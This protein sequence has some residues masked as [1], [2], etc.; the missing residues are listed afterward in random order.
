MP[1]HAKVEMVVHP[2][3][4]NVRIAT[5]H[6]GQV[7]G[8]AQIQTQRCPIT[9]WASCD[10]EALEA[11]LGRLA[12]CIAK[13]RGAP[14]ASA[15]AFQDWAKDTASK[16][17]KAKVIT[18]L[19]TQAKAVAKNPA[20]ARAGGLSTVVVPG[21]SRAVL[22]LQSASE[23]IAALKRKDPKTVTAWRLM[24]VNAKAGNEKAKRSV[25]VVYAVARAPRI[26]SPHAAQAAPHAAAHPSHVARPVHPAHVAHH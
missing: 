7:I 20:V 6:S 17:A 25:H 3:L 13:M 12:A 9:F 2:P 15:G 19:A 23:M 10:L 8:M 26:I 11:V 4:V 24:L 1:T 21:T 22:A 18:D 5:D 14:S 16:I